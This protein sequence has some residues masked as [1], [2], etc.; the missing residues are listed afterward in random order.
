L[1]YERWLTLGLHHGLDFANT[2]KPLRPRAFR[3]LVRP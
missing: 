2:S 3:F 1:I